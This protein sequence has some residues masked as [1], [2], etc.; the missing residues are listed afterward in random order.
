MHTLV[1]VCLAMGLLWLAG[2]VPSTATLTA[3]ADNAAGLPNPASVYCEDQGGQLE[4]RSDGNGTYGVCIFDDG[5]ECEEWAYFR[6][7]CLPGEMDAAIPSGRAPSLLDTDWQLISLRGGPL[8]EDTQIT[9]RFEERWLSGFAGCNIYGGGPDSG[10]YAVTA[11]GDL[12]IPLVAITVMDCPSPEGVMEQEQVY[13]DALT[14]AAAY[15]V[16]DARLEIQ[17][18]AR[19]TIL[20][21]VRQEELDMDPSEL[22]GTAWQLVSMNG[23]SPAEGSSITLAFQDARWISG[24]TGC[25]DYLAVYGAE[26]DDLDLVFTAILGPVCPDDALVEQEGAYTTILGWTNRF[27]LSETQLELLTTRGEVL[28]FTPTREEDKAVLEGP[29]WSLLAFVAP[30]ATEDMPGPLTIPAEALQVSEITVTFDGDTL[31]VSARCNSY[32]AAYARDG[33]SLT[34]EPIAPTVMDCP[35]PEGVMEQEGRYLGVLKNVIAYHVHGGQLWLETDDGRA[36]VFRAPTA[37]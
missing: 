34:I 32:E 16:A 14:D 17:N 31:R 1:M 20:V 11:E 13:V 30:N 8:L 15:S 37:D 12:S 10:K 3:E 35:S 33:S 29:T 21:Y 2:C 27:R 19:D 26:G 25:R 9:I 23:A 5:S 28:V 7:E 24:H 4:M 6:G 22:V 18:A 36:L